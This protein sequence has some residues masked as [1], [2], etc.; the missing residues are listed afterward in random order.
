MLS[1]NDVVAKLA[2]IEEHAERAIE[3]HPHGLWLERQRMI[4]SLAKHLKAQLEERLQAATGGVVFGRRWDDL[5][6]A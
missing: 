3:E 5:P 1:V 2:Q 4:L 6:R